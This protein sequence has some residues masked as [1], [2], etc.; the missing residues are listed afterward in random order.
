MNVTEITRKVTRLYGDSTSFITLNQQDIFDW[1]NEAQLTIT[2]QTD[3]LT[4]TLTSL[5][6]T[7]PKNLPADWVKTKRVSYNS[8]PVQ[9]LKFIEIEDLDNLNIDPTLPV[10]VPAFFYHWAGQLRLYPMITTTGLNITHDYVKLPTT[11]TSTA[12]P[13]DVPVSFHEDIVRFCIMRA[14]ERNENW[15]AFRESKL[16]IADNGGLRQDEANVSDDEN[17]VVRD[18]PGE[19][20][21]YGSLW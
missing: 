17:F 13:L 15:N 12:I 1:I 5:L 19:R 6:S 21:P 3:V 10:D 16:I 2:R 4:G 11:I 7:Y 8:N 9:S 14:H 20:E 18:D